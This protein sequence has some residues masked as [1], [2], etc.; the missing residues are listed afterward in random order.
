MNKEFKLSDTPQ[1]IKDNYQMLLIQKHNFNEEQYNKLIEL[2]FLLTNLNINNDKIL[3][4][5][6]QWQ[7]STNIK[8]YE[9]EIDPNDDYI[10]NHTLITL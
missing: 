6:K 2:G 7:I 4:Q 5:Y 8:P 1:F 3:F 9:Y 10:E